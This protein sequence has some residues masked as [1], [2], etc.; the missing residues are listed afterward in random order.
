MRTVSEKLIDIHGQHEHQSL[1]HPSSHLK[2]LD[3]FGGAEIAKAK[4][5]V[6]ELFQKVQEIEQRLKQLGGQ[7]GQRERRMDLLQ[8]QIDEIEA[9]QVHVGED[10]QLRLE[11]T[12]LT[13]A[14]KIY[15]AFAQTESGLF[16]QDETVGAYTLLL[17]LIHI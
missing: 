2:L 14:E 15:A 12:K 6:I 4:G 13:N 5:I 7:D 17:S 9:A 8:Y 10:E 16:G 1:L 3:A 11:R